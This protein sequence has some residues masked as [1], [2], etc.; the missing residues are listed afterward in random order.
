M[1]KIL[2]S[3]SGNCN[4]A[5]Q[6]EILTQYIVMMTQIL[7]SGSGNCDIALQLVI[8]TQCIVMRRKDDPKF[9]ACEWKLGYRHF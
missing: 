1:T 2:M 4:I 6:L 7:M 9:N 3:G 5:L 8:L